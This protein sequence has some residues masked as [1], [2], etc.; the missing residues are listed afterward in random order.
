MTNSLANISKKKS[1]PKIA[2]DLGARPLKQKQAK[3]KKEKRN[4]LKPR[5]AGKVEFMFSTCQ[6]RRDK[7]I[8]RAVIAVLASR[9]S[10]LF[11]KL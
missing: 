8:P 7:L 3:E 9:I 5:G 10:T 11:S 1:I 2:I 4:D 6:A